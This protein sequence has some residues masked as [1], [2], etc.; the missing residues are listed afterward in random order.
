MKHLSSHGH[1]DCQCYDE[2]ERWYVH[3]DD[4]LRGEPSYK[5]HFGVPTPPLVTEDGRI[6]TVQNIINCPD[7]RIYKYF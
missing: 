5:F 4:G 1:V 7:K 2:D 3:C 6:V